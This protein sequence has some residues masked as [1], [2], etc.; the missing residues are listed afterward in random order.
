MKV[1][2]KILQCD[3]RGQIVIAKKIRDELNIEEGTGF[4]AYIIE[5]EGIFL[6]I[7]PSKDLKDNTNALNEIKKKAKKLGIDPKNID[8]SIKKYQR[9][10]NMKKV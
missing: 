4:F 10:E 7:I 9:K 3:E 6:K 5:N 1:Y 2:P 8:I